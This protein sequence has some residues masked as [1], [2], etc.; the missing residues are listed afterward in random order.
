[1]NDNNIIIRCENLVKQY[2]SGESYLTVLKEISLEVKK[3]EILAIVGPS[4]AGKSTL[5]HILGLLDTPTSGT[6]YFKQSDLSKLTSMEQSR[7]R[8]KAFG[9]VFQF[10]HLIPELDV[11]ENTLLP[12]MIDY[13]IFGWLAQKR[14]LSQRAKELLVELGLANRIHHRVGLLSGGEKQRVAIAR[15]LVNNPEIVFCDEP[16]GNLDSVTSQEIQELIWNLNQKEGI[17]FVIV[18]HEESI[19]RRAHRFLRLIDGIILS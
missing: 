7:I 12:Y 1:M 8:N 13:S 19:A 4:G 14:H 11:L 16:T 18:T 17:T 5:L 2:P 6:V 9:F 10:Y 3:G 15:A